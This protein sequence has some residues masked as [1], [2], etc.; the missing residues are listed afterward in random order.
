MVYFYLKDGH[1]LLIGDQKGRAKVEKDREDCY[2][3]D[4]SLKKK[5]TPLGLV[6]LNASN[7]FIWHTHD[8]P[9]ILSTINS[10]A[11]AMNIY[12][13]PLSIF[14]FLPSVLFLPSYT[15]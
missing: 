8:Y 9:P 6:K 2:I 10:I 1:L 13:A 12:N 11:L 4:T 7:D 14:A 3:V 5:E 15:I